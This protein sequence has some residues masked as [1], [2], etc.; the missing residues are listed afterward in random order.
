MQFAMKTEDSQTRV[1]PKMLSH[2]HSGKCNYGTNHSYHMSNLDANIQLF[3][4]P[5]HTIFGGEGGA[6]VHVTQR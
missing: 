1:V 6:P 5:G 3:P 4:P 2:D